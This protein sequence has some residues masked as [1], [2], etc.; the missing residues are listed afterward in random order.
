VCHVNA[1]A[2]EAANMAAKVAAEWSAG[3]TAFVVTVELNIYLSIPVIF[4]FTLESQVIERE[5]LRVRG[6][7]SF[8][9]LNYQG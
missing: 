2:K 9:Q 8:V 3:V 6:R 7:R 4:E 5:A 1:A